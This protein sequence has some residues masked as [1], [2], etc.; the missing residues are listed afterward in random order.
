MHIYVYVCVYIY[1]YMYHLG[2]SL[3]QE[4]G[5]QRARM[6][7]PVRRHPARRADGGLCGLLLSTSPESQVA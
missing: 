1:I 3:S 5:Q 6:L 2:S 4:Q 7:R